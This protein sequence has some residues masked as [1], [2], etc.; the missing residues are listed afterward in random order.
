MDVT[1][2]H[3]DWRDMEDYHSQEER[4]ERGE[5]LS[6]RGEGFGLPMSK[7]ETISLIT[8]SFADLTSVWR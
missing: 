6:K 8:M 7:S 3:L 5:E 1:S 2:N 4:T